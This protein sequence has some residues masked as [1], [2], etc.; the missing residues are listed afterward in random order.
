V[1]HYNIQAHLDPRREWIEG[2][3][4]MRLRVRSAALGTLTLRLAESLVVR[5]VT[6]PGLGRL[7]SLRVKGQNSVIVNLPR[8]L[9]RDEELTLTVSYAGRIASAIPERETIAVAQD[10]V[11][12][13][14]VIPAEPRTL[15]TNRS[16][17]Y[18]Q[19]PSTD[20]ATAMLRLTMP[21]DQSCVASG[22]PASGN[23]VR[24]D[25]PTPLEKRRLYVFV[26]DRP[27]RY[28]A[29]VLSRLAPAGSTI[30]RLPQSANP[31]ASSGASG[32]V[33]QPADPR[34]LD[35]LSLT[36]VANPRQVGRA[37]TLQDQAT[38]VLSIYS[39]IIGE[40][41][42]P[43]FTLTLVDDPLPG[44]H[45]PAYFALLHQ[46]MPTSPYTWR[47]DPVSFDGFP[48]FF[49]AHELAHQFW[50]NAVGWENYHEQWISEGIAQYFAVL[51]AER[52]R[53]RDDFLSILRQL[54][55]TAA[56]Q[57]RYGPVWLG[58]RL[59][60]LQSDGRIFR[61]LVYNK[62][63]LVLHMLRRLIG[64]ETFFEGLR[65]FYRDSRYRKVGTGQLQRAFES[66]SG[67]TLERFFEQWILGSGTPTLRATY[68]VESAGAAT[69][70]GPPGG[71]PALSPAGASPVAVVRLEQLGEVFTFPVTVTLI[72]TSGTEEEVLVRLTERVV[73]T[74][75]PL[76]GVVR[77]LEVNRDNAALVEVV[78]E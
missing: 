72:Y 61:A 31:S 32:E 66:V 38:S 60:H 71:G 14:I 77:S 12:E 55:R 22:S 64:D 75:V 24:I 44:G 19:A 65:R 28:F 42:Y 10:V 76:R 35:E 9:A 54:K 15:Y 50:G 13:Q 36:L 63:A 34:A 43:S 69:A 2:R 67:L 30:V 26:V 47:N 29:V 78:R 25:G 73:E 59:G 45:S 51:Y 23:P 4:E 1:Q 33:P 3:T 41:P 62:G 56:S 16:Y 57:S 46:Q 17:W 68:T 18:A 58:Y 74:R 52:T 70:T 6:T 49:L 8:I 39:G 37:R 53:P 27:A 40:F 5:A 20:F 11:Q 48:E 21:E 7:L